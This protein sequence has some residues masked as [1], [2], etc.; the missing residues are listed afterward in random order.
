MMQGSIKERLKEKLTFILQED[1]SFT[2]GTRENVPTMVTEA[3]KKARESLP[4]IL[5]SLQDRKQGHHLKRRMEEK[6]VM[7]YT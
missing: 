1:C 4:L 7:D 5:F 2:H 6:E 3:G